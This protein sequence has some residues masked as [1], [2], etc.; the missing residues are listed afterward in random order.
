[1]TDEESDFTEHEKV[2]IETALAEIKLA[3][4]VLYDLLS[5]VAHNEE[6]DEDEFSQT[7]GVVYSFARS[8]NPTMEGTEE[9]G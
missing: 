8:K 7:L 4:P 5:W 3:N 2:N 9:D 6:Y 1:M